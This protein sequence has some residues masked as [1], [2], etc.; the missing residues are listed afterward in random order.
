MSLSAC[1]SYLDISKAQG[2]FHFRME[3]FHVYAYPGS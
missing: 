2:N 3:G 1:L